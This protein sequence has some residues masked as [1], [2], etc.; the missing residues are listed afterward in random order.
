LP[1]RTRSYTIAASGAV[2]DVD[3]FDLA[4]FGGGERRSTFRTAVGRV[5][6]SY[7]M[8]VRN[9]DPNRQFVLLALGM[10]C[11]GLSDRR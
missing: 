8:R 4:T 3:Q 5:A 7:R 2:W 6:N 1:S 10:D 9:H 11:F